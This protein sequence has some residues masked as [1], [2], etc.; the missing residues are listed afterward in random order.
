MCLTVLPVMTGGVTTMSN[1]ALFRVGA[2]T[3]DVGAVLF[4]DGG[5][6]IYKRRSQLFFGAKLITTSGYVNEHKC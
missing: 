4:I 5:F 1:G 6:M 2:V 3:I